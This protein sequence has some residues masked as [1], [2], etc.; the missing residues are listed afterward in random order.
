MVHTPPD[1]PRGPI[2]PPRTASRPDSLD[3]FSGW[4]FWRGVTVPHGAAGPPSGRRT[5]HL[6]RGPR[7][8]RLRRPGAPRHRAASR[9]SPGPSPLKGTTMHALTCVDCS[10]GPGTEFR[11][12]PDGLFACRRPPRLGRRRLRRPWLRHQ[13]DHARGAGLTATPRTI[14]AWLAG[15]LAGSS[16]KI[17]DHLED[18][19]EDGRPL[20]VS[21]HRRVHVSPSASR[22][23]T[24][25]R[26]PA[27]C[28]QPHQLADH[29]R[30]Q[31]SQKD[32]RKVR[33]LS[34][35]LS[36]DL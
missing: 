29:R 16:I 32:H 7:S 8:G 17:G 4:G 20:N 5:L 11:A 12:L 36:L 6:R 33:T 19:Q 15:T 2:V 23:C 31:H 28:S 25:Y 22:S 9:A 27:A 24:R 26:L 35:T 34:A 3:A 1:P 30:L 13:S 10:T 21:V 14:R 18:P